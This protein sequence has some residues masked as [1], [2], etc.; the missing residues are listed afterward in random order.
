[1]LRLSSRRACSFSAACRSLAR[2]HPQ[3]PRAPAVRGDARILHPGVLPQSRDQPHPLLQP[4]ENWRRAHR[5]A[6]GSKDS[7]Q[8]GGSGRVAPPNGRRSARRAPRWLPAALRQKHSAILLRTLPRTRRGSGDAAF[9]RAFLLDCPHRTALAYA[10]TS[11]IGGDALDPA[12]VGEI[13]L[14]EAVLLFAFMPSAGRSSRPRR[15]R[16]LR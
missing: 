1:M 13:G 14:G 11:G 8:R 3:P 7:H 16:V 2:P 5:N 15:R 12:A 9:L 10:F 6:G 4:K